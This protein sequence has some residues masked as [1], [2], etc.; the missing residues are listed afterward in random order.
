M[1]DGESIILANGE[2]PKRGGTAWKV[3]ADAK[4]VV[5]CDGA[6]DAYRRRFHRSPD[7]V[8]GD[9]DSLHGKYENIVIIDE[10]DTNDLEKAICYCRQHNIIKPLVLGIT[11]K[12]DDHTLGNI[13]RAFAYGLDVLTNFGRF[14]YVKKR[15]SLSVKV[16]TPISVFA[17]SPATKMS[18]T[19]LE[20]VLKGVKFDNL[21][22][23]TLNR[24]NSKK[25]SVTTNYPV[26]IYV[27][28]S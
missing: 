4:Y 3:L 10:Q 7:V 24:A 15:L 5:C 16:G 1:K 25:I 13:F 21:Y 12:R 28:S 22:C 26:Y 20:W 14:I 17:M 9:C 27:A 11:G 8:V 6:A 18:S 23:A 2:F 19:G